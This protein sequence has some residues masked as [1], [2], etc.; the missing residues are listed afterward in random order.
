MKISEGVWSVSN[1]D[2]CSVSIH[3]DQ[4]RVIKHICMS[5]LGYRITREEALANTVLISK[6]PEL[7][8]ELTRLA[9]IICEGHPLPDETEEL[10]LFLKKSLA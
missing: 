3:D 10:L 5:N 7:Y 1:V 6:A 2:P 8:Q 9:N 4:G